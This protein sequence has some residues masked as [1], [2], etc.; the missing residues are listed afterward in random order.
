[1]AAIPEL[2]WNTGNCLFWQTG[3][4]HWMDTVDEQYEGMLNTEKDTPAL[5]NKGSY[6]NMNGAMARFLK[7]PMMNNRILMKNGHLTSV[8]SEPAD[9][10]IIQQAAE[11]LT[12][13][14]KKQL[15]RGKNFLFVLAPSQISKYESLLPA[16]YTDTTNETADQLLAM[17]NETGVPYLDLRQSLEADG[18]STT[19]AFFKTDHHWLPQTGFW[20]YTKI[21]DKLD[22]MG[23]IQAPDS[24]YTDSRQFTFETYKNTFL[25]SWGKRTGIYYA[26][27]DDTVFIKPDFH[28][29]I[30]ISIPTRDLSLTGPYEEIA[31]NTEAQ[32]N[33]ED[34]DYFQENMY[35]LYGWGDTALTMWRNSQAPVDKKMLLIG[36]SFG[37][38]PFSLMSIACTSC[39][40]IDLRYYEDNFTA[41]YE[42][43]APDMVI[44]LTNLDMCLSDFTTYPYFQN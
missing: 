42:K 12:L 26:G 7:Q 17:L 5:Q 27:V 39:D 18:I 3:P 19:D 28:T 25:G 34:P 15:E 41:Y 20:A 13:F 43:Y 4:F 8:V 2:A 38:I 9:P 35:A 16:G 33:L 36:E 22:R 44:I 29:E 30:S 32:H 1:M 23:A 6:I 10:A 37:N 31:Y 21:L 24:R 40:E 11:N 14:H